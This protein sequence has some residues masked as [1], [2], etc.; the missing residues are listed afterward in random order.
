MK[1]RLLE[2][3]VRCCSPFSLVNVFFKTLR[4]AIFTALHVVQD[5]LRPPKVEVH[6]STL[7]TDGFHPKVHH[8]AAILRF[9]PSLDLYSSFRHYEYVVFV[10]LV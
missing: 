4:L 8:R 3:E 9:L 5:T 1:K 10:V 2:V 6:Q 7:S